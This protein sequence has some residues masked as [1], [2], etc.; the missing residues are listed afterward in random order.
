MCGIRSHG[1]GGDGGAQG[2]S[3]LPYVVGGRAG[4]ASGLSLGS[5][6]L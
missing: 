1:R 5:D 4:A 2:M 3:S 6:A